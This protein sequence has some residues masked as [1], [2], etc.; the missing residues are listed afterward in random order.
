MK[1]LLTL[2]SLGITSAMLA[3][4]KNVMISN[5][6]SPSEVSI[7]INPKNTN[8]IVAGANLNNAF[9]STDAGLTWTIKKITETTLGVYG[10]PIIFVDTAGTFFYS[11]LADP[12]NGSWIDRIVFQK[13]TNGGQTWGAGTYTGLNGT[14][15]QDKEGIVV[16]PFNNEIYVTWTEFDKYASTSKTDSSR[17]MFSKSADGG[18]TWSTA[19]KISKTSGDCVDG[20]NTIE[21]AVPCV[22]P[23]GEIY[24]SWTGPKGIVFNKSLDGGLTWLPHETPVVPVPGGWDYNI[25][26]LQRCNGLPQTICDLSGGP[27]N[28]TIYINWS[29]QRNGSTD[30]DVW[31]V[32]STDGGKTWSQPIR[33]NDDPAGKQN[34]MSWMN[35]DKTNGYLYVVFYDRR[36]YTGTSQKTDLYLARSTNGGKSFTNFKIN[37]TSFSPDAAT[38]FG[39]YISLSVHNNIVRPIWMQLNAGALSVWTAI[40][41]GTTLFTNEYTLKNSVVALEQNYP[42]PFSQT[43]V[44]SFSLKKPASVSLFV[45]DAIGKKVA[46]LL[47]NELY[48][49]GNF[50]YIFNASSANL[51]SG[52]YYYTLS[53]EESQVTKKMIV[54]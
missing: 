34:F 14:K 46:T 40:V 35:Y 9:Y 28:G 10:D 30:T 26:G 20:D 13:S 19:K 42:N 21:G 43:T 29:D 50:D 45:F 41:D 54:Y 12:P 11:H 23:G 36:N 52:I 25:S 44:I 2:I 31:I 51:P 37:Q 32:T 1:Q 49:T 8:Q 7:C 3:Q 17:I 24:V 15:V 22:G 39:D 4:F 48:K 6:N 33:V 5:T 38:F 27:N 47:D 18:K 53:S 16:N